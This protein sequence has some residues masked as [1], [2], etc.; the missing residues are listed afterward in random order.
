MACDEA[1]ELARAFGTSDS[2]RFVNGILDRLA[3]PSAKPPGQA[4]PPAPEA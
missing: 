3:K 4:A 2:P 1:I